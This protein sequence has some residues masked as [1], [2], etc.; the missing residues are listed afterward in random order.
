MNPSQ[1]TTQASDGTPLDPSVVALAK[2]IRKAE[3]NDDY[4]SPGKSGE[5]GAYQFT[6]PMWRNAAQKYLGNADADVR[7][8][9]NQDKVAYY[10]IL[11]DKQAGLMPEQI[12]SKWNSGNP[13]AYL[14]NHKG[15]NKYG[16][17]YDTPAYVSKVVA[18]Y[19]N[20]KGQYQLKATNPDGTQSLGDAAGSSW[21]NNPSI[22]G[23]GLQAGGQ[24][25]LNLPGDFVGAVGGYIKG[26]NPLTTLGKIGDIG[27][28][29]TQLAKEKGESGQYSLSPELS[30]IWDIVKGLPQAAW[31][32]IAPQSAQKLVKGDIEGAADAFV[33]HPFS[34]AA[35]YVFAAQG[36]AKLA[37]YAQNRFTGLN[38]AANNFKP[39]QTDEQGNYI[40]NSGGNSANTMGT[41]DNAIKNGDVPAETVYKDVPNKIYQ[42]NIAQQ[43]IND[44]KQSLAEKGFPE[45]GNQLANSL[46]PNNL[47]PTSL[48]DTANK[49]IDQHGNTYSNLFDTGVQK[50]ASPVTTPAKFVG[51]IAS[52]VG[53]SILSHVTGLDPKTMQAVLSDPAS[54]SRLQRE[55]TSRTSVAN[56]FGNDLDQLIEDKGQTGKAYDVLRQN[57]TPVPIP[58]D[59]LSNALDKFGL[60]LEDGKVIADSNSITRNPADIAA[61][62]RFVDN[63]GDKTTLT[64]N[65]FLNMRSDLGDISKFDSAK[66]PASATIGKELYAQLNDQVRPQMEGL[67]QLDSQ[68]SPQIELYKSAKKDFLNPDGTF[69]DGAVNKIVNA[70]GAGKDNLLNRMEQVSPGIT[71]SIKV[72]KAVEDIER[73][74][75]LKVGTY[76]RGIL[77]GGGIITGNM[78]LII[79]AILTSP[80]SAVAILRAAGYTGQAVLPITNALRTLSGNSLPAIGTG[81]KISAF[82]QS[83]LPQNAQKQ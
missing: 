8:P 45:I 50:L 73:A 76:T 12:A 43:V 24:A 29:V 25:L 41:Y 54:F 13:N 6:E 47:T 7:D 83:N 14:Q 32:T 61:V 74:N 23:A 52:Q 42:P 5:Y 64:P 28:G 17:A 49:L 68:M 62:Q 10:Q 20:L 81:L 75:G 39:G 30:A 78:P 48:M 51:H 22:I 21:K 15:I 57:K 38:D 82:N 36:A 9:R 19:Q 70:T 69:K 58:E 66:S 67:E 3:S 59:M 1:S 35:P 44:A 11:E 16:V 37:D 65:E 55:A 56:E 34:E 4:T 53:Q 77:E 31:Q 26:L 46:D 60:R 27:T 80:E 72:L 71:Q 18:N 63:W 2:S 33:Q 40:S 79:S